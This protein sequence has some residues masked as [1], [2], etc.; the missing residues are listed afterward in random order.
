M[1]FS[2][3]SNFFNNTRD[4]DML[5]HNCSLYLVEYLVAVI[6][7]ELLPCFHYGK[8]NKEAYCLAYRSPEAMPSQIVVMW[9]RV[10]SLLLPKNVPGSSPVCRAPWFCLVLPQYVQRL[11]TMFNESRALARWRQYIQKT[12]HLGCG[13]FLITFFFLSLSLKVFQEIKNEK[14][15]CDHDDFFSWCSQFLTRFN[16]K[17]IL[18]E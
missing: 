7:C 5:F 9:I 12:S 15:K 3:L 1:I 14:G 11:W 17:N 16:S 13:T 10:P 6:I 4:E 18:I 2:Q 8:R